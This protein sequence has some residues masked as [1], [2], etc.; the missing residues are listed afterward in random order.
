MGATGGEGRIVSPV[1][2]DSDAVKAP[3]CIGVARRSHWKVVISKP[4]AGDHLEAGE[5][6]VT[7]ISLCGLRGIGQNAGRGTTATNP[8]LEEALQNPRNGE[9]AVEK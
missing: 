9:T 6:A 2:E 4:L 7:F 5:I 1:G 8:Y 3:L